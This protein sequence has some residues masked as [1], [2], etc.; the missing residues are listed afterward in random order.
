LIDRQRST[1]VQEPKNEAEGKATERRSL[2]DATIRHNLN[3][4]SRF[5]SWA[6]ERGH[7]TTN[8]VRMIPVGKRPQQTPKS[9]QPW[10][11]DDAVVRT[12]VN[13]L[14]E[15]YGLDVLPG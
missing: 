9:D 12:L 1:P 5:F 3:L 11:D 4:L 10:L 6:I 7:A 8:P 15:M 13:K 2:S 14:P